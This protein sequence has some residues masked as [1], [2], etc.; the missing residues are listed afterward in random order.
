MTDRAAGGATSGETYVRKQAIGDVIVNVVLTVLINGWLTVGLATI[1][2]SLPFGSTAPS[3]GGTFFGIALFESLL[4]TPIVFALTVFQRKA[5]KVAPPLAPDARF[6]AA[7]ARR[8]V[9]H[10]VITIAAAIA[11]GA[12]VT[13]VSPGLQLPRV[14]FLGL[15]GLTAGALALILSVSTTRSALRLR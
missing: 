6:G 12:L 13:S 5:G 15:A 4:L 8:T 9:A 11:I 2:G 14:A 3:L 1:P 10:L 7:S